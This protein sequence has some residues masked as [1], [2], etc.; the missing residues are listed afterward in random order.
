VLVSDDGLY[1]RS[2]IFSGQGF[3]S[4]TDL[5]FDTQAARYVRIELSGASPN[6]WWSIHDIA[7]Y[8]TEDPTVYRPVLDSN[9]WVLSASSSVSDAPLAID[10]SDATRWTARTS[11]KPGQVFQIDLQRIESFDGIQLD[12]RSNPNDYPRGYRVL[13]S[14]DGVLWRDP[15]AS[16]AGDGPVTGIRFPMQKVRHLRIEQ[17]GSDATHWWSIHEIFVEK[18]FK[19]NLLSKPLPPNTASN[20]VVPQRS[21]PVITQG[22]TAARTST[23]P[24]DGAIER[25]QRE[26]ER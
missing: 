5:Y 7:L 8:Q 21:I 24:E 16:G 12:T 20:A 14:D 2:P 23:P 11:Q 4:L 19:R 18:T 13:V 22:R 25:T 3:R 26:P 15:A 17:T 6:R 10:G 9:G 1:W